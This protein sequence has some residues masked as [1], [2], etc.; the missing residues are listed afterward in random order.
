[1]TIETLTAAAGRTRGSFYHHF[2][3]RE[4]FLRALIAEWRKKTLDMR[5]AALPAPATPASLRAFLREEPMRL[6]HVFER[7]VRFLV[8]T[9]PSL[10]P[11]LDEVD[12]AR[13][14]A[15][16]MLISVLRPEIADPKSHALVQ[17]AALV[18]AQWLISDPA[19]P[20][21]AGFLDLAHDLF[22]LIDD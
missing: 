22:K 1:M 17:Y 9:E 11:D 7:A 2:K 10:R 18:G 20:R 14:D 12:A 6:D 15:L 5:A 21:L 4:T 3:D 8:A 16:A 19:D 13:V